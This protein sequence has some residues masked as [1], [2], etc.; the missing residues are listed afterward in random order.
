MLNLWSSLLHIFISKKFFAFTCTNNYSKVFIKFSGHSYI[1]PM[2]DS[3]IVL[4]VLIVVYT[5]TQNVMSGSVLG[6]SSEKGGCQV[7]VMEE[8]LMA[9]LRSLTLSRNPVLHNSYICC[10][11]Y[12]NYSYFPCMRRLKGFPYNSVE[13]ILP[14]L[15][16]WTNE[17]LRPV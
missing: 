7:R 11:D 13:V 12:I 4:V 2:M 15:T 16:H 5:S 9:T 1:P 6:R 14:N 8:Q 3:C 10:T 17:L